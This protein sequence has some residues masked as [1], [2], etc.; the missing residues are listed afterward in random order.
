MKRLLL[1]SLL[2]LCVSMSVPA[3][4][5]VKFLAIDSAGE[6]EPYATVR[7]FKAGNPTKVVVTGVTDLNGKFNQQLTA[8]GD[9]KLT[10]AAVGKVNVDRDFTVNNSAKIAN[11]GTIVLGANAQTLKEVTVTAQAPLVSNEIDRLSYNVQNDEDSKSKTIFDMLRKVPLVSVDGQDNIKVKGGGNFKIYKNGHPDPSISKNPKEVLKAIPANMIRKIEVITEPGAKYDAEG[12]NAIL[13]IVTMSDVTFKGVTGTVSAGMSNN[14]SPNANTYI[15]TQLGKFITSLNYGYQRHSSQDQKQG[16]HGII[17]Y[18]NGNSLHE[19]HNGIAS[20][21]VH[22][23]N[24]EMSFEPDTLNLLS[25]SFGGYYYDYTGNGVGKNSLVDKLNNVISAYNL[26]T[27]YPRNSFHS[28][29]GRF[30]YQHKT[31]VKDETLTLSYMLSTSRN[32]SNANTLIIDPVNAPFPYTGYGNDR[33]EN[34]WEH[35]FQFDWTRPFAKYHKVETGIKYIYRLNKSQFTQNYT[36]AEMLNVDSRFNHL[37]QVVAAYTSYT[38]TKGKWAARAGLRYEYSYLNAKFPDGSQQKFHRKLSDWVPSTSLNYQID[39]ANSLKWAFATRINRPG[40]SYLNPAIEDGPSDKQYGNSK[41]S[42]S[43]HYSTSLTFMHIGSKFTFN[44]VPGFAFSNNEICS[45]QWVENNKTVTTY[46]NAM[47]SLWAGASGFVQWQPFMGTSITV[48]ASCG[49]ESHKNSSIGIEGNGWGSSF[50]AQ[51][52]Q[53][54]PWELRFTFAGGMWKSAPEL[55]G[56]DNNAGWYDFGVQRS[57]LKD[58]RLTV[59][60]NASRPFNKYSHF[61]EYFDRGDY[62]GFRDTFYPG[63]RFT[64]SVSYRFGNLNATV[65]KTNTTIENNDLVGGNNK[66]GKK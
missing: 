46:A 53:Q 64:I 52:S 36:E 37:T 21:N 45:V 8:E 28:F 31:H 5:S 48:N 38:F 55:Y 65:K 22:Y 40:I 16:H 3:Q 44:I 39:M 59:N 54:L 42:S 61:K 19:N 27:N 14:A 66:G 10:I 24:I 43:R 6:G 25:L 23:G 1:L 41:L 18:P 34:F 60:I 57:L 47:R 50:Y 4:Y 26:K 62:T 2:T 15:T 9:Y 49:Y 56:H 63:R 35:T 11:L 12:V 51:I 7:I 30:D 33:H 58:N 29:D 17:H 32:H 20:A 13:N